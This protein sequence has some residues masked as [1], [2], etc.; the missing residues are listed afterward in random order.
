MLGEGLLHAL[1][2]QN[3][4]RA[5]LKK[6]AD[7]GVP[8][9]IEELGSR[10]LDVG[11]RVRRQCDGGVC[12]A[13]VTHHFLTVL[14]EARGG[15]RPPERIAGEGNRHEFRFVLGDEVARNSHER[16]LTVRNGGE[17]NGV[18]K[19]GGRG[20]HEDEGEGV[21]ILNQPGI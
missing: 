11:R 7:A 13:V 8:L 6:V 3:L 2:V 18:N 20:E 15:V 12:N 5:Q 4:V 10:A 9:H 17:A 16:D 19:G 1:L 14:G 21:G